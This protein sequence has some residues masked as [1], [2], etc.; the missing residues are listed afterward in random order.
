MHFT[1]NSGAIF[2]ISNQWLKLKTSNQLVKAEHLI[3]QIQLLNI[4][5]QLYRQFQ[6]GNY[7]H[8]K[9]KLT[10]HQDHCLQ[11]NVTV[12]DS[13]II[14]L[15]TLD[16]NGKILTVSSAGSL[17]NPSNVV[18]GSTR[19]CSQ[20]QENIISIFLMLQGLV[21]C[22]LLLQISEVQKSEGAWCSDPEYKEILWYY[23]GK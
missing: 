22:W 1:I 4:T 8:S 10:I 13:L 16:L 12:N 20:L 5:E 17:L 7:V 15:R 21:Q 18:K 14:Q 11:N 23:P 2:N 6:R 3:L 19:I 9:L